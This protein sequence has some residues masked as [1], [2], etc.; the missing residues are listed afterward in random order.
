MVS[1]KSEQKSVIF[2]YLVYGQKAVTENA[3]VYSYLFW[4][5]QKS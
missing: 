5:Q 4:I 1:R 2:I 3:L